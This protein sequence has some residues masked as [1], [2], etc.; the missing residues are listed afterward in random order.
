LLDAFSEKEA[1]MRSARWFGV[2]AVVLGA[3]LAAWQLVPSAEAATTVR[4][5]SG[6]IEVGSNSFPVV[7]VENTSTTTRSATITVLDANGVAQDSYPVTGVT[8]VTPDA[9]KV[10]TIG[11]RCLSGPCEWRILV[12]TNT[13]KMIPSV[14]Y[15]AGDASAQAIH[16]GDWMVKVTK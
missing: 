1:G 10:G 11:F 6:S 3:V 5:Y 8:T 12:T 2:I 14:S 4:Y 15:A 9:N 16:P 7:S 13:T